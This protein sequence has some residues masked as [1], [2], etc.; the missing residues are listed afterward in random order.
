L[1]LAVLLVALIAGTAWLDTTPVHLVRNCAAS[2]VG[3]WNA[4][5]PQEQPQG[6]AHNDYRHRHPLTSALAHGF[7]S[8]EA[9]VWPVHG[10]LLV[11][12]DRDQVD[13]SRTLES[14][15]LRPLARAVRA[16]AAGTDVQLLVDVKGTAAGTLPLL[17][18]ELAS[19]AG[20]LT[21]YRAGDDGCTAAPGPVSVVVSGN[22]HPVAPDPGTTSLYGYDQPLQRG[23][24]PTV[25][26]AV[27]P[28]AS[29]DW[30]DFFTWDGRGRMPTREHDRLVAM[31]DAAHAAGSRIRFWDTPDDPG[32]ARDALWRE[33][34]ADGVDY[35]NTDDLAG[36]A[37]FRRQSQLVP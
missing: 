35:I 13:V 19:Y 23:E 30:S 37:A 1:R 9:D 3:L 7:T 33:L 15:Y 25:E 18:T 21:R 32:P 8:V 5:L 6:H 29:G 10:Q 2:P 22:A 11:A 16:D 36:Y 34:A 27:T 17:R 24:D 20:M 12:H 14:L 28:L 4:A 26:D 31:V